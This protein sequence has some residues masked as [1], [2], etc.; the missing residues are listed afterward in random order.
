MAFDNYA[1][2]N[3]LAR[4]LSDRMKAESK[5]PLVLD[6]GSIGGDYSLTTNTFPVKIP[7]GDYSVCR[8]LTL[9]EAGSYLTS[10]DVGGSHGHSGGS[11]GGHQS[12]TGSHNHD[13]GSHGHSVTIPDKMQSVKPGDRVLV[14]WVQNEAVVIDIITTL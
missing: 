2:S 13:G 12:G 11:H 6:F 9:G 7:R 4:T 3:K 1:G 5:K 10:T 8:Q 14:A